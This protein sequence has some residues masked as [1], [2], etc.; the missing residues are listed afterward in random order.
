[1]MQVGSHGIGAGSWCG[2]SGIDIA[3]RDFRVKAVGW[4]LYRVLG[5]TARPIPAY[6]GGVSLGYQEPA[7][8]VDEARALVGQGERALKLR[9]V[10]THESAIVRVSSLR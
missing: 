2:Q 8:L 7:K 10:D 6:A 5:G 4:P 1:M 9:I 3:L